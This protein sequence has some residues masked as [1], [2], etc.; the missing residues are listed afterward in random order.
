MSFALKTYEDMTQSEK[1]L[2][3][4]FFKPR[5]FQR[6]EVISDY[7]EV[8]R[9]V[10]EYV[11]AYGECF[12]LDEGNLQSGDWVLVGYELPT[13]VIWEEPVN[14]WESVQIIR[15]YLPGEEPEILKPII[16]T[17]KNEEYL[18]NEDWEYCDA[19]G[20]RIMLPRYKQVA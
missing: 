2:A 14:C 20:K 13:T 11:E 1:D 17:F 19:Q 16:D 6:P 15:Q 4:V 3:F 12:Q 10:R 8:H 7:H 5:L 9:L 18:I